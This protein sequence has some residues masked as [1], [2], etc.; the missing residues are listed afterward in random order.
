MSA[1]R[2]G[3]Y[4][5]SM[6]GM[7]SAC[8]IVGAGPTGLTLAVE[9][10][11]AGVPFR[12]IDTSLHPARYSQA[13]V[14]QARTLEQMDR[15]S[16]AQRAVAGGVALH[17]TTVWSDGERIGSIDLGHIPS[18]FP[19][20]LVHPQNETE[21]LLLDHLR[22]LGVEVERGVTLGS[23]AQEKDGTGVVAQLQHADGPREEVRTRWLAGCDGAHSTVRHGLAV[24]F[25]GETVVLGFALGD[26]CLVGP[27]LP[28]DGM[29]LYWHKGGE[30]LLI[31]RLPNGAHRVI[32]TFPLAP[33]AEPASPTVESFNA[34]FDRFG[35][36]VTA[37][38]AE[39]LAPFRV[40]ERQVSSYRERNVFLAG[41]AAHVH[42][43]VGGQ[44]MNTGMQDVAN[45]GWKL[46]A[47]ARGAPEALL[48]SYNAERHAVGKAVLRGSGFGL[49]AVTTGSSVLEHVR[50]FAARH[51]LPL[52]AVQ[53]T[54]ARAISETGIGYRHSKIVCDD[55]H[56]GPLRAGDRFPD[57][58]LRGK[59][60][61]NGAANG[62][63]AE[64]TTLLGSLRSGQHLL[65]A[66]DVPEEQLPHHLQN[67]SVVMHRSSEPGW[68]PPLTEVFGPGPLL[69]LVRPDG[70]V[71]YRGTRD[72][73]AL[74]T[75]A[76]NVGLT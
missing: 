29:H 73:E 21:A 57:A 44:G 19:F 43:P 50:D 11:R 8:L 75:Y 12:L 59:S 61:E 1:L 51:L 39:W 41:D 33:G 49:R 72:G 62:A 31:A 27:D 26:L 64:A 53:N 66:L 13:L 71:G 46:G 23:F 40:N 76:R 52:E 10:H 65:L 25:E 28:A 69:F 74:R 5:P 56:G 3:V 38:S 35:V 48:E 55:A 15:Y 18:R 42:S 67:T 34:E 32:T 6:A 54:A 4:G 14:V 30:A 45:L 58:V 2:R 47:V 20:M 70:Y 16:L 63:A 7:D 36:R 68:S 9:L 24:G 22:S 17:S 37:E 60:A